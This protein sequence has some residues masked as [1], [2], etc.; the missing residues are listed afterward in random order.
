[1]RNSYIH[2]S[3]RWTNDLI[4]ASRIGLLPAGTNY[5]VPDAYAVARAR[6]NNGVIFTPASVGHAVRVPLDNESR[7]GLNTL[8]FGTSLSIIARDYYNL[9]VSVIDDDTYTRVSFSY[10][11]II[12][13]TSWATYYMTL[14]SEH[15]DAIAAGDASPLDPW[16][17][18]TMPPDFTSWPGVVTPSGFAPLD[19]PEFTGTPTVPTALPGTNTTQIASTAFVMSNVASG[20]AGVAS[21]N[22]RVGLVTLTLADVTDATG[23]GSTAQTN[24]GL[25]TV[26][27]TGAYSDL[28]GS[29]AE[30]PAGP[31]GPQGDPGPEGP[32]GDP[33]PEGPEG[34]QG[35]PGPEGPEGPEGPQGG[36]GP[37]G[38]AGADGAEGPE[39]PEGLAGPQ[40]GPGPTGPQG[41]AGADGAQG[42]VGPPGPAGADSTVPGPQGPTGPPGANSTVPGPQGP[43]GDPGTAGA[44][45]SQGPKGDPGT[46]G[47]AGAQ[48]PAGPSAVSANAGNTA[49]LGT[50]QLI[51]VPTP[52]IPVAAS[53]TPVMDG[54]AAVGTGTTWARADHIHASD[55]SRA[56]LASPTFTG[57]VR[58]PLGATAT[59]SLNFGTVDTGIYGIGSGASAAIGF[60]RAGGN[61]LVLQSGTIVA[62]NPIVGASG[63]AAAPGYSFITS[64]SMGMYRDGTAGGLA[65]S[66]GSN[67]V[68]LLLTDTGRTATFYGVASGISPPAAATATELVTAAWVKAKGY[69]I[70]LQMTQAAYNAL[71]TKDPSTLYVIVG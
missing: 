29:P 19:S 21:F 17:D 51:Y 64:S 43:K 56:P 18:N 63:S 60:S 45:G 54:T 20:T 5:T 23:S 62:Y 39:G 37:Q 46:Q 11:E 8:C 41:P 10:D 48:G 38:P 3:G 40:G 30:G 2:G 67:G 57:T 31:Q 4:A 35:D 13:V 42:D 65:F 34:P 55:T 6:R 7:L 50:D 44:T 66:T 9:K 26:A 36:P 24:L 1:M 71:G 14:L 33:G 53:T 15:A 47:P 27:A 49:S 22:S 58:L 28:I 68:G 16:P 12:L 32:Q 61:A 69:G 52:A 59:P 70:W 25:A